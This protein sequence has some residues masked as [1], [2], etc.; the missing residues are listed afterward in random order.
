M[1]NPARRL[2]APLLGGFLWLPA[3]SPVLAQMGPLPPPPPGE[4]WRPVNPRPL[5]PGPQPLQPGQ[6][7]QLQTTLLLRSGDLIQAVHRSPETLLIAPGETRAVSLSLDTP[8][9]DIYGNTVV[10][11]GAVLEGQF[12]PVSG[13]TQ[14]VSRALIFNGQSYPLYAQSQVIPLRKDPR[15]TSAEA[16]VQDA[17]IGAAAGAI[18]G[19]LFGD[20]VISTE[21]VLGGAA[22][23][24][25]IGNVTAPEVAVIDPNAN[26][27]L[28]VTQDFQPYLP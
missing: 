26:L 5:P 15:H 28:T 21:K 19:G 17:L 7:F 2:L 1:T 23:G 9:R 13:G 18:L 22:A 24:A 27:T 3:A 11:A 12:Q 8:L 20:R 6:P 25:V 16:V 10:P 14:F 4:G